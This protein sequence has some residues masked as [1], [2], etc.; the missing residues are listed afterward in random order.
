VAFQRP[1]AGRR[2]AQGRSE[3]RATKRPSTREAPAERCIPAID[4]IRSFTTL[5]NGSLSPY[6]CAASWGSLTFPDY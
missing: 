5:D 4:K 6:A 1:R 3:G 2:R